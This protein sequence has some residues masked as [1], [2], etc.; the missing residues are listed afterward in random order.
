M[1]IADYSRQKIISLTFPMRH[2]I[3]ENKFFW[4]KEYPCINLE[5]SEKCALEFPIFVWVQCN[6]ES[7]AG[8]RSALSNHGNIPAVLVNFLAQYLSRTNVPSSAA[9]LSVYQ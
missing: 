3:L 8:K 4:E 6:A 2:K 1:A 5:A 7:A 9:I